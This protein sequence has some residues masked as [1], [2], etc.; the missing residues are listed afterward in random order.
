MNEEKKP[1][2]DF[3]KITAEVER[4]RE[5]TEALRKSGI[6]EEVMIAFLYYKTK[7]SISTIKKLLTAEKDF[8][9]RLS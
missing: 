1:V 4:L 8:Y 5:A 2:L 6:D 3:G 7:I 9:R